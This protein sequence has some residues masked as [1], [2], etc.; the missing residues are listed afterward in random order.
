MTITELMKCHEIQ[1]LESYVVNGEVI[2]EVLLGLK[3]TQD[4]GEMRWLPTHTSPSHTEQ[5]TTACRQRK[6]VRKSLKS[7]ELRC[8]PIELS[9]TETNCLMIVADSF[10]AEQTLM[11][12]AL[13]QIYVNYNI[14]I[15]Q[16]E[17]DKLTGLLNRSSLER[18]YNSLVE[19]QMQMQRELQAT[20]EKRNLSQQD[21]TWLAL[22]D[23]DHFKKIND[24]F[25]H[26]CGDEVL[27]R[28]SQ[29]MKG[30]FRK[31][32]LLFRYGGEEF[33]IILEPISKSAA[34]QKLEA[35]R[36]FV[37]HAD[38][39]LIEKITISIGFT[40]ISSNEYYQNAIERADKALYYAKENGRNAVY[41][42]EDLKE[43][44]AIYT[45]DIDAG[46]V[47]LF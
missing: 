31:S 4:T 39:P 12:D 45:T 13:V 20:N 27:L 47:D 16:S 3:K 2:I 8:V 38:F 9:E 6:N 36:K 18:R 40:S 7:G 22:I 5:V 33:L 37:G 15:Q 29:Y 14:L 42:Y 1:L 28:L 35:F 46:D 21:S 30:M 25:G 43:K 32:D 24:T 11:L 34:V 26:L 41:S 19:K 17:K 10:T 23:I 44:G